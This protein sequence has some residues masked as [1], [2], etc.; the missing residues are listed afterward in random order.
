[1]ET[2]VP[3]VIAVTGHRDLLAAEVTSVRARVLNLFSR[4]QEQFPDLPIQL[5]SPLAEGA[6]RLTAK[7]ALELGMDLIVPVPMPREN[8]AEDFESEAS[9]REFDEL[10]A[11]GT[12]IELPIVEGL[13]LEQI[14]QPGPTRALQYAQLGVFM[15]SHCQI[16]LAVWD[17]VEVDLLGGTSQ[18]VR[19]HLTDAMPGFVERSLESPKLLAGNENDLVY[20]IVCTRERSPHVTGGE[21]HENDAGFYTA[22]T[23]RQLTPELPDDYRRMFNQIQSF[24]TDLTQR[25]D[26]AER[27]SLMNRDTA[28]PFSDAARL[29]DR[30]F[31]CVD[32]LAQIYQQRVNFSLLTLH[33]LAVLL[34]VSFLAYS[35]FENME[36]MIWF[37]L[38]FFSSGVAL[39]IVAKRFDW[40]RKYL[41]YRALAEG[42]RVQFYWRVAGVE[43]G[44]GTAFIHDNFLQKQDIEVGWIRDVMRY[45]SLCATQRANGPTTSGLAYAIEHWIGSDDENGQGQLE[46]YKRTARRR[47][48]THRVTRAL[49]LSCLWFGIGIAF[50][51]AVSGGS[52]QP[53]TQNLVVALMG[54]F[55]LVAAVREAYA[56]KKADKEL[57]KQY[58]F[59][60]RLFSNARERIDRAETDAEKRA[61]LRALGTAALDEHAE[62]ILM[63]R[64]RPLEHG[65]L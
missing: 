14:S 1:M 48:R 27:E 44:S 8:Y 11:A 52:V 63:H 16:L 59:M 42:L 29:I 17:G 35:D 22:S 23:Y 2:P 25:T 31:M 33:L 45:V 5:M 34:G 55:P 30:Y 62:W 47:A 60:R 32:R 10:C 3:L 13:S 39:Y 36:F 18:V 15:S 51:L 19:F 7:V 54:A 38:L 12:V 58:Q 65:K 21:L 43:E 50:L 64:E 37:F 57:I 20:Q 6:G 61:I 9:R 41:D 26:D 40:H 53:E 4:L 56:H 28:T 46:Y 49:G 24:N